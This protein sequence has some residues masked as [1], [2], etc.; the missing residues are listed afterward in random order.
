MANIFLSYDEINNFV[1]NKAQKTI[2][3]DLYVIT[4]NEQL[5]NGNEIKV[6]V[7]LIHNNG[8]RDSF[9]T[10]F[11]CKVQNLESNRVKFLCTNNNMNLD[12]YSLR[13]NNS[14]NISGVPDD[15]ILLDPILTK[16]YKTISEQKNIPVF[17]YE[18]IKYDECKSTGVFT[19]LG[20]FSEKI[21][22]SKKFNLPLTY[23]EGITLACEVNK[24]ED[25]I[26]C[27]VDREINNSIIIIEQTVI[28]I[29]TVDYINLNSIKSNEKL[30]CLNGALEDSIKKE[31]NKISFR[32]V[33]HFIKNNNGFSFILIALVTEK[34]EKGK[35]LSINIYINNEKDDI[36]I[37]CILENSVA[38]KSEQTQANFL[39]SVDKNKNDYWKNLTY[40]NISISISPNN[41]LINGVS[42]LDEIMSNPEKTD[43]EIKKIKEKLQ[44]NESVND[45]TNII[46]YY[47]VKIEINTLTL[48]DDININKCN[49]NGQLTLKGSFLYDIDENINFDL[50]LTYPNVELKCELNKVKKNLK[51]NI[52]CKIQTG[53]KSVEKI[54]IESKLI[55]KKNQELF[56]IQ[57]KTFDLDGKQSCEKYNTIKKQIIEKR[58]ST[59]IYYAL[60][61][62]LK[63]VNQ[64]ITFFMALT[65]KTSSNTFNNYYSFNTIFIFSNRRNLRNLEETTYSDVVVT[66]YQS[67][68]LDLTAGYNCRSESGN[69]PGTPVSFKIDTDEVN[70][71]SLIE[72]LNS[73]SSKSALNNIDFTNK[74]NLQKINSLPQVT[75]NNINGDSCF[76]NGQ[77]IIT[78]EIS[79]ISNLDNKY[80]NIEIQFSLPESTGLCNIEINKFDKKIKMT[81]ENREKFS[82]SQIMIDRSLIQDSKGNY[83]FTIDSYTSPEQFSCDISL[84][85]IAI[86][87]SEEI[88]PSSSIPSSSSPSSSS[89][90]EEPYYNNRKKKSNNGLSAGAIVGIIIGCVVVAAAVIIVIMIMKKRIISGKA[91]NRIGEHSSSANIR[92]KNDN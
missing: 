34:M 1:Y 83:I 27:K 60:M 14:V 66:C 52:I 57:G 48:E 38:P 32:Q 17:T 64:I 88:K 82:I 65:K 80:S 13:Y 86:K 6:N 79:D 33:S 44:K 73:D 58:Q 46:D 72:K 37:D 45:L 62:Q 10:E 35:K 85:S 92:N 31:N 67:L 18:S 11:T 53:F 3:F 59:G 68:I 71:I 24:G 20:K 81:C 23:P 54:V 49:T 8:T 78:G 26:K 15:E 4:S 41:E 5:T 30:T 61:N 29:E 91:N 51:T 63:I 47:S 87:K 42:D 12:Y 69:Y 76:K 43:E 55:K 50:P 7:N 9:S 22:E 21:N 90:K 36:P 89:G 28:K 74:S 70:D 75:I 2:N 40:N 84:N 25:Q 77:Y 19:I 16:K 39:C 56:Y